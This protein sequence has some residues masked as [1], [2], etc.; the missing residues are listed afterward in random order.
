[1]GPTLRLAV[2]GLAVSALAACG[3]GS[4]HRGAR[5]A[6]IRP[7]ASKALRRIDADVAALKRASRLPTRSTLRGNAAINRATD[8]FL[9][10]VELAPI[11]NLQRNRLI[12]HAAA[13]LVGS[14]EQCFQALEA[15][16]PIVT[17]VDSSHRGDCPK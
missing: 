7:G 4:G 5:A 14:C 10:D 1:M 11:S 15:G 9:R 12:D 8:A 6:C 2:L 3:G 17:V 13:A 16:R